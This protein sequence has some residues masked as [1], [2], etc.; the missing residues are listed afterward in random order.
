VHAVTW[1]SPKFRDLY[2]RHVPE[3]RRD[4]L[5]LRHVVGVPREEIRQGAAAKLTLLAKVKQTTGAELDP[6]VLTIAVARPGSGLQAR[7][8][9]V[10]GSSV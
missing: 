4:N 6:A 9:L 5:Y 1:T 3:W 2:D 10:H 8:P 7:R